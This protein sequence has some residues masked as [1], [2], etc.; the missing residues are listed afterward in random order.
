MSDPL[1]LVFL[2]LDFVQAEI[3]E[4]L[5]LRII[6]ISQKKSL[7][8]IITVFK[9]ALKGSLASSCEICFHCWSPRVENTNNISISSPLI[10]KDLF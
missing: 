5:L 3:D 4:I 6:K 8:S 7:H 1:I 10:S 2:R 9:R